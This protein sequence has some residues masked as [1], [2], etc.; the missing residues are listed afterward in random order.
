MSDD[1][2]RLGYKSNSPYRNNP[3]LLINSPKGVITMNGVNKPLIVKDLQN[4]DTRLLQPNSGNHF[5]KGTKMLETPYNNDTKDK[6]S[7]NMDYRIKPWSGSFREEVQ[8]RR[9]G[10]W[11]F[12]EL[13]GD[14]KLLPYLKRQ[15][16]GMTE[17]R[18]DTIGKDFG[19]SD[20]S[21][22]S[23]NF[24]D[25]VHELIDTDKFNSVPQSIQSELSFFKSNPEH[26]DKLTESY[27]KKYIPALYQ[28][29]TSSDKV[30]QPNNLNTE[31]S[32]PGT[33][34]TIKDFE[35]RD[36]P[37]FQYGGHTD[38]QS[39]NN[40]KQES[41]NPEPSKYDTGMRIM[42]RS[43]G[44]IKE[45]VIEHYDPITGDIKLY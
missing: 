42:Y 20:E 5:F 19:S 29:L 9:N 27:V 31:P 35:T 6:M 17:L 18:E 24:N 7:K 2:S 43:G 40:A 1:V 10:G 39:Y 45:G 8:T 28:Y 22:K 37:K 25:R 11:L 15:D 26:Q 44:Q 32:K 41:R 30:K 23:I 12:N 4:N 3:Q 33:T 13:N 36:D 38:F 21:V 16:G 34:A 14:G